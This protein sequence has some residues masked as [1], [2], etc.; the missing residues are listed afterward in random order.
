[1]SAT[2]KIQH[3]R[4]TTANWAASNPILL[5]GEIGI[6]FQTGGATAWKVGNGI[7]AWA[8]L[9]YVTGPEGPAGPAGG[10]SGGTGAPSNT[11]VTVSITG[12]VYSGPESL[13]VGSLTTQG[14]GWYTLRGDRITKIVNNTNGMETMAHFP[15]GGDVGCFLPV[16]AGQSLTMYWSQGVTPVVKFTPKV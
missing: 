6:E 15:T 8:Q 2:Y 14:N 7:S 3:R 12:T 16:G 1:M 4:D 11:S 9:P 5:A 10:G 13:M